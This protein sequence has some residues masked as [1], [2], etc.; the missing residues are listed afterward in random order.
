MVRRLEDDF[1][2]PGKEPEFDRPAN[3]V[4]WSR[5]GLNVSA[6]AIASC[7]GGPGNIHLLSLGDLS[8]GIIRNDDL[9]FPLLIFEK[10]RRYLNTITAGINPAVPLERADGQSCLGTPAHRG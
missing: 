5:Y 7:G 8:H 3:V 1:L 10:V 6:L 9:Q 4:R 2:L